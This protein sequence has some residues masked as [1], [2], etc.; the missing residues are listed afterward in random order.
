MAIQPYGPIAPFDVHPLYHQDPLYQQYQ[1]QLQLQQQLEQQQ[2]HLLRLQLASLNDDRRIANV[3]PRASEAFLLPAAPP[4]PASH[5][6]RRSTRSLSRTGT[7]RQRVRAISSG[8]G[9][10]GPRLPPPEPPTPGYS[11]A[12]TTNSVPLLPPSSP[13]RRAV[14]SSALPALGAAVSGSPRDAAS[15]R[16]RWDGT[17]S[18][19]YSNASR[20]GVVWYF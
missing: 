16:G 20:P 5:R 19:S 13:S 2:Q 12:T 9:S 11:I 15:P 7:G 6:R 3:Q 1:Y 8:A 18:T 10:D 14:D 17:A 4:S